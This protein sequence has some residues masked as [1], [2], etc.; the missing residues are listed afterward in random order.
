MA[1]EWEIFTRTTA[2]GRTEHIL[3][4]KDPNSGCGCLI[5]ALLI[6][7]ILLFPFAFTSLL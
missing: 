7:F 4:E 1:K 5:G 2:W 6:I 3:R